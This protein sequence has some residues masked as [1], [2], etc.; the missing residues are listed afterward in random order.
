MNKFL[1]SLFL[2]TTNCNTGKLKVIADLPTSLKE[3]SAIEKIKDSNIF[4]IIEDAG[5]KNNLY[6]INTKGKIVKDIKITN[7]KNIDWEDLTCDNEGNIK[8]FN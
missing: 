6:G 5:N 7:A 8:L 1:I 2:L 4:W 3:T